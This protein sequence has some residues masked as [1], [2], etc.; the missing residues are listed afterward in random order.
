[1]IRKNSEDYKDLRCVP[2]SP[3]HTDGSIERHT[4]WFLPRQMFDT[5]RMPG[6]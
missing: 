6:S 2:Q 1:M 3:E 5:Q 4:V